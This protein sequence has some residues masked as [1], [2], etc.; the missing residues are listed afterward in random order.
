WFFDE[1]DDEL[2]I[3]VKRE[4]YREQAT[5]WLLSKVEQ[6]IAGRSEAEVAR[7]VRDGPIVI[8][9]GAVPLAP[10]RW[11]GDLDPIATSLFSRL[12]LLHESEDKLGNDVSESYLS[13]IDSSGRV[14]PGSTEV[15][16]ACAVR[17]DLLGHPVLQVAVLNALAQSL[18]RRTDGVDRA[19]F[20]D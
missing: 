11:L 20:Q 2:R 9:I 5:L 16:R 15:L 7:E 14:N 19:T 13:C 6:V 18:T 8:G 12:R 4:H 1:L 10:P 3:T 17:A